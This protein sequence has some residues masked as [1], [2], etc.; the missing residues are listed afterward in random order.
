MKVTAN[1]DFEVLLIKPIQRYAIK[2]L[3][4]IKTA[5]FEQ[6]IF[7]TENKSKDKFFK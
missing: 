3:K 6:K 2:Y 5:L 4:I 7:M 1:S